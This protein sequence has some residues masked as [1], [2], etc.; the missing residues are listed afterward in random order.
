[1]VSE[2]KLRSTQPEESN[3]KK[4]R[5]FFSVL[6]ILTVIAAGL[7]FLYTITLPTPLSAG[8]CGPCGGPVQTVTGHGN[9][10]SCAQALNLAY[11]NALS[12]AHQGGT[13]CSPCNF[14]NGPQGCFV[15]SAGVTGAYTLYYQCQSCNPQTGKPF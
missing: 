11:Q 12:M 5:T 4:M 3:M 15:S 8:E 13:S 2:T 1:M 14:S 6:T 7:V 9:G 10:S